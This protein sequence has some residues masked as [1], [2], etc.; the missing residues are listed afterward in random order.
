M[1]T[2]KKPAKNFA[3]EPGRCRVV[4]VYGHPD[5][6]MLAVRV[7]GNLAQRFKDDVAFEFSWWGFKY[8]KEPG[9]AHQAVRAATNADLIFISPGSTDELPWEVKAWFDLWLPQRKSL[10]GALVVLR[11]EP[12]A[13]NQVN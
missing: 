4:A 2:S 13:P 1:F 8:L 3:N 12:A 10:E 7:C 5:G 11:N 6:R 9:I